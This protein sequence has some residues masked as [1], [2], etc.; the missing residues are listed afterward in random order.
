MKN[1]SSLWQPLFDVPDLVR[2][3]REFRW[4]RAV[5]SYKD[6]KAY[7]IFKGFAG[8]RTIFRGPRYLASNISLKLMELGVGKLGR[9]APAVKAMKLSAYIAV[10]FDVALWL[11]GDQHTASRLFGT[12]MCDL[13]KAGVA[14]LAGYGA[15][16][17]MAGL[18]AVVAAPVVVTFLV[19]AGVG[20]A[21]DAADRQLGVTDALVLQ[22]EAAEKSVVGQGREVLRA[23]GSYEY[24]LKRMLMM[25]AARAAVQK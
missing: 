12:I 4:N 10:P 9:A 16:V 20:M 22:M 13:L 5:L 17:V 18:T 11:L 1:A 2:V 21:L 8:K 19:G 25:L 7:I 24:A 3:L 23:F 15:G 6:G 14:T